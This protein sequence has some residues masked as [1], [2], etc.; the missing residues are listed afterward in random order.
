MARLAD[1]CLFHVEVC[2]G[3]RQYGHCS[4]EMKYRPGGLL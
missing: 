3:I 2:Y 1:M 4:R